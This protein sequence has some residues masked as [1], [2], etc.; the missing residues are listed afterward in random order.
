MVKNIF[1]NFGVNSV[2]DLTKV[3]LIGIDFGNDNFCGAWV[4]VD[5]HDRLKI[6]LLDV[7]RTIS[8]KKDS[9]I[10]F[11]PKDVENE[12]TIGQEALNDDISGRAGKLYTKFNRVGSAAKER[13]ENS[14]IS[15]YSYENLMRICFNQIINKYY[16]NNRNC[17]LNDRTILLVG[18]PSSEDWIYSE[19]EYAK[20]LERGLKIKNYNGTVDIIIAAESLAVLAYVTMPEANYIKKGDVVPIFNCGAS[21]FGFTLILEDHIPTNGEYSCRFGSELIEK[22]MLQQFF[23]EGHTA[24]NLATSYDEMLLKGRK[25]N[26]FESIGGNN[27]TKIES[28]TIEFLDSTE[29]SFR[30]NEKFMTK[31]IYDTEIHVE[32]SSP[33]VPQKKYNSWY[34]ACDDFF[35]ESKKI[36]NKCCGEKYSLNKIVLT[37][38]AINM[39]VISEIVKN[40][41]GIT[42]I[43]DI[44]SSCTVA[45]GLAYMGAVEALK[46]K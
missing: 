28:Y 23:T 3:N 37:G 22:C 5:I 25:E 12:I 35:A 39:P 21:T 14:D 10:L 29:V 34:A 18:R 7:E 24:E 36:I 4:Y 43:L 30:I 27:A 32:S 11:I 42:P 9:T 6:E 44:H 40:R 15:E 17:F 2:T 8:R 20:L 16:Q 46:S 13:Y 38:G 19:L 41:F 45:T 26:Y 31:A 1:E 33:S